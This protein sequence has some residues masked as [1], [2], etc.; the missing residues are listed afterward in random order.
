[1][2]GSEGLGVRRKIPTSSEPNSGCVLTEVQKIKSATLADRFEP[3]A[4]RHK[5]S[6]ANDT[7]LII[8]NEKTD[9]YW[10]TAQNWVTISAKDAKKR[11]RIFALMPEDTIGPSGCEIQRR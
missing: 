5:R 3:L 9:R 1:M 10:R 7:S 6:I 11:Q 8:L 4:F 2:E